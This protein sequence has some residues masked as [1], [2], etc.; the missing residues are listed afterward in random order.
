M[1]EGAAGRQD[2]PRSEL[3]RL[4]VADRGAGALRAR[5]WAQQAGVELV[6][7]IGPQDGDALWPDDVDF[8]VYVPAGEGPW[9][10][11]ERALSAAYD[12]GCDAIH[13]G[14]SPLG[15]STAL[16]ELLATSALAWAGAGHHA[17]GVCADRAITR[18]TAEEVGIQVVPGSMPILDEA[19]GHLWTA[20]VG[21]PVRL[22]PARGGEGTRRVVREQ[23]EVGAAL[24]AAL[25][26][27]PI[28]IERMVSG[29]REVEVPVLWDGVG[30]PLT[31][32]DRDLTVH[33][34]AGRVVVEA[35]APGL[36]AKARAAMAQAAGAFVKHA[37]LRGLCAVRFLVAPDGRAYLLQ[38]I[39]GLS[40]WHAVTEALF[41]IDLFDAQVRIATG[42]ALR[43]DAADLVPA[44]HHVWMRLRAEAEGELEELPDMELRRDLALVIGD[45]VEAGD[46]VGAVV[47]GAPTRQAAI[48]RARA[49]LDGP[50]TPGVPIDRRALDQVFDSVEFWGGP[51]DRD[52]VAALIGS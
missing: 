52:R 19:Q 13:P 38:V 32:G 30:A 43:I 29:A 35:P 46:E 26:E 25:G 37:Q 17:L 18:A 42:D 5:R 33:D 28:L 40:P 14:Y 31:L 41:A 10:N 47:V 45:R 2:P 3:R 1:S 34:T 22:R 6:A 20:R 15:R 27:G 7:L 12:A 16:V 8:S 51:L 50:L 44:G 23:A 48:V 24:A 9:P 39:P 21:L 11:A 4:L 36:S 49:S